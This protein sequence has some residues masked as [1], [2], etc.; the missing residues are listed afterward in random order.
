MTILTKKKLTWQIAP[1]V[2]NTL[3]NF[4]SQKFPMNGHSV[5]P[6]MISVACHR[7]GTYSALLKL[8]RLT[9]MFEISAGFDVHEQIHAKVVIQP[10]M[11]PKNL[12]YFGANAA[13]QRY[14]APTVGSMEAISAS[15]KAMSV[16]PRPE[17]M[18]PYA[19]DAGPPFASE[20]WNVTAAASQEHCRRKEKLM[21]EGAL[22]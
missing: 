14:C 5:N 18:L 15:D 10:C 9:I 3:M 11:S 21:A 1:A 20:N 8:A 2:S 13:D 17:K 6:H 4:G 22:M 7:C 19:M 12:L 16:V